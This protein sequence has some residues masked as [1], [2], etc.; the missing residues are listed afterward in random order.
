MRKLSNRKGQALI[1]V[2]A[3]MLLLLFLGMI[4]FEHSTGL[5]KQT[6]ALIAYSDAETADN[7]LPDAT[8]LILNDLYTDSI[9]GALAS[10]K[11]SHQDEWEV[12]KFSSKLLTELVKLPDLLTASLTDFLHDDLEANYD[13]SCRFTNISSNPVELIVEAAREGQNQSIMLTFSLHKPTITNS[14]SNDKNTGTYL[15][16]QDPLIIL[17]ALEY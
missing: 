12:E 5:V 11:F 7:V 1:T 6:N 9:D 10:A 17:E 14:D 8:Y 4:L 3:F 13:I 15:S 16:G 2:L